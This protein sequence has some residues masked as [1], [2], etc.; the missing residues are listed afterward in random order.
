MNMSKRHNQG[1]TLI[2]L[3][4]VS[5]IVGALATMCFPLFGYLRE[6]S[7]D[8]ACIG[9]L[10]ILQLGAATYML[11]HDAVWPQMPDDLRS[12]DD[13]QPMWEWWF[14]EL[15]DYGVA[16][17]HWSCPS[18]IASQEQE[19][20]ISDEFYGSYI[21]TSFDPTPNIAFYWTSQPWF[22]ERGQM[23][24]EN[25]GPNIAMPDGTV[26]Q[27]PALFMQR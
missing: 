7:R 18:E 11:D 14:E 4:M 24:G 6:K 23:H 13:E 15:K 10:R 12:G 8:A 1:F 25:H 26:R 27:G 5:A 19:H 2:E 21:P 17:R 20:S 22:I 9:N 3:L 16:K